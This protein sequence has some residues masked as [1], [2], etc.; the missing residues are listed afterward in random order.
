MKK[1][2]DLTE[3]N[4]KLASL[5][6]RHGIKRFYLTGAGNSLMSGYAAIHRNMPLFKRNETLQAIFKKHDIDVLSIH[7]SRN[8]N[9]NDEHIGDYFRENITEEDMYRYNRIDLMK[10]DT[11][12]KG[13]DDEKMEEYY[14]EKPKENHGFRDVVLEKGPD[15]ANVLV[16]IGATGSFLDNITRGGLPK[17]ISG[18]KRDYTSIEATLKEIQSS[19]RKNGTNTQVYLVGIP[20]YLGLPVTDIAINNNLKKIAAQYANVTYVDPI[21]AKLF[22]KEGVDIHLNEEEYLEYNE[23]IM[24][25]IYENYLSVA[26]TI[27]IDRALCELNKILEL[28]AMESIGGHGFDVNSEYYQTL[29]QKLVTECDWP[30]ELAKKIVE[31]SITNKKQKYDETVKESF[32][33][34]IWPLV[35]KH[36][37]ELEKEGL[38]TEAFLNNLRSYLLNRTPY[39]FYYAGKENI[40]KIR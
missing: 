14:P 5:L 7:F 37:T 21:K 29:I 35:D 3:V 4:E 31:D 9:N 23:T 28:D 12:A 36:V 11:P 16:Y 26:V 40:S 18:F 2:T 38:D 33:E 17:I 13:M 39:D 30:K 34:T 22:Y 27:E 24:E 32:D 25:S 6:A 20:K 10:P 19:N 8:Q 15:L 1:N